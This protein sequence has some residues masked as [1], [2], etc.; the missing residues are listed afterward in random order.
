ME[1]SG[2]GT[3]AQA[4]IE[5]PPIKLATKIFQCLRKKP[6][7]ENADTVAVLK[8]S[9]LRTEPRCPHFGVCGGCSMQHVEFNGQV[10]VKQRVMEDSLAHIGK[11]KAERILPPIAGPAWGYRHRA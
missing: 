6:S 1:T 9:F 10:A 3:S 2:S 11:V 7:F 8:E 5:N 4:A